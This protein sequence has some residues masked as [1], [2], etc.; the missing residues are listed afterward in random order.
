MRPPRPR[1]ALA[2]GRRRGANYNRALSTLAK[3]SWVRVGR[4]DDLDGAGPFAL[5]GAGAELVAI[6]TPSGLKAYQGLC[7]HQGTLLGEGE[8]DGDALVCRGHRWR[9]DVE[10]GERLGGPQ[11]LVACPVEMR[12]GD[13][14][15]D[16][17]PLR[18]HEQAATTLRSIRDLPGP[19]G[20]PL[21]GNVLQFKP[22]HAHEILEQW[23]DEHGPLFKLRLGPIHVLVVADPELGAQI[24]LARPGRFRR[25]SNLAP[26]LEELN[27]NGLFAAEGTAWRPQ[28]K[29]A[30]NA[31]SN[32]HLKT[33]YP[34]LRLVAER[35]HRRW[36]KKADAGAPLDLA[37]ELKRFAVDV[38]T[39]LVMG[40]DV[41]TTEQEGDVIQRKLELFTPAISK[42]VFAILPTWRWIRTPADRRLDGAVVDVQVWLAERVAEARERLREDPERADRP[43]NFL[44]SMLAARDEEGR[45]FA[46]DVI[47]GNAMTMLIAGEET[48][49]YTLAWATHHLCEAP[50][51]V[52]AL[53]AEAESLLGD[54]SVALDID[55]ANRLAYAGAV[56]DEAMRLRS[57]V[58]FLLLE[59]NDDLEVGDV[60]VPRGTWVSVLTRRPVLAEGHFYSADEFLPERW[61]GERTNGKAHNTSTHMPFGSGPRICPGRTLALVEM[62]VL[63]SMLYH[64][65]EVDRVGDASDVEERF[66]WT[67][68]PSGLRVRLRRR[69]GVY[70]P[71][72]PSRS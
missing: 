24:L 45:P 70:G 3:S 8:L 52:A 22:V 36:Q 27:G 14:W 12:D 30:M 29:L 7:P 4:S 10:T 23:A 44:Q 6:R 54:D 19:R 62:K 40:Y 26:I 25:A 5:S 16:I 42:R 2:L 28:R 46:D 68:T 71:S 13:L 33:F 72:R 1:R 38:T 48:T 66:S 50:G 63:L 37:D 60:A 65:F 35:L 43:E 39:L 9:F 53:R 55:T 47:F 69:A 11:C 67:M 59:A 51:A 17:S 64:S 32:R 18:Q 34:T 20:I 58:P 41:N 49:A 56:A 61:L 31:L 21:L 57:V 15:A